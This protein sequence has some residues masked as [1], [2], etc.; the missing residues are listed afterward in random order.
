[1]HDSFLYKE[2]MMEESLQAAHAAIKEL[3]KRIAEKASIRDQYAMAVL[4]GVMC[5]HDNLMPETVAEI[6]IRYADAMMEARK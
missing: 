3:S 5:R 4:T 1:M 6:A 2:Q